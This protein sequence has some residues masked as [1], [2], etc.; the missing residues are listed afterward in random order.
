MM[1]RAAT[2]AWCT[3]LTREVCHA[4]ASTTRPAWAGLR[5]AVALT[6]P[7]AR[8]CLSGGGERLAGTVV[9]GAASTGGSSV[10]G[11]SEVLT[12]ASSSSSAGDA[13]AAVAETTTTTPVDLL[14]AYFAQ[15]HMAVEPLVQALGGGAYAPTWWAGVI[16]GT[17]VLRLA[18]T[19]PLAVVQR[20][21]MRRWAEVQGMIGGWAST[22]KA[23]GARR[24]RVASAVATAE[25]PNV[26]TSGAERAAANAEAKARF[27]AKV[28]QLYR[29]H[30]C[31]PLQTFL[32]PWVQIPLFVTA[33][34]A[35]RSLAAYPLPSIF[36]IR[37]REVPASGLDEGG[38][39][40]FVDLTA[41]DPTL[42]LP[43]A[44]GIANWA[45]IEVNSN[46]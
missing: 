32:L 6:P 34:L 42:L 4:A 11:P 23:A 12:G 3:K 29:Q 38:I 21:R 28:R 30:R 39:L 8:R 7:A 25:G 1:R 37:S 18:L 9:T 22:L 43:V 2:A 45:N 16:A 14:A 20:R 5:P 35:L 13:L 26:G 27:K 41:P 46:A 24:E 17:V 33:S 40:W 31:H 36:G 10:A 44:I 15:S 19:A